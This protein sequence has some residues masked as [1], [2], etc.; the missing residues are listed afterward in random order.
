[1]SDAV[2]DARALLGRLGVGFETTP[3][4]D[5]VAAALAAQA[6]A[7]GDRATRK[8][9]RR[10]LYRLEQA[11][12]PVP[13]RSAAA[14]PTPILGPSID[15]WVSAV[16]GRGDRLVWLVREHANGTLTL[17]AADLNEPDGLRDLRSFDVTRKQLRAMRERFE[18]EAGLTFVPAAWRQ[19]DALVLEAQ[20]RLGP[21]PDRRLDYRRLRPR[22]TT[23]APQDARELASSRLAPVD[24]TERRRLVAE[25]DALA[26]ERELRSW[27]PRPEQAAPYL[28][29]LRAVRESPIV[30]TPVQQE[31]RLREVLRQAARALYPPAVIAR[32]LEATAFVF[33]ETGRPDAARRALAVAAT[34]RA[35]PDTEIP[36][37]QALT[38]QGLGA[39]MAA[40]EAER[41]D[42]RAAS[43]VRTPDEIAGGSARAESRARPPRARG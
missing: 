20:D 24:D 18:R 29:E 23:L 22:L 13:A 7:V 9:I 43:L 6:D 28:A 39:Y 2:A 36:L 5:A 32:R 35:H 42:E 40:T 26:S 1:M 33:A 15:A 27:W 14:A 30:L 41:R 38:Q 12:V 37:V 8:E 17:V 25:S 19:V 3:S 10:A 11:G 34:L 31:E 4:A 21:S 16:D